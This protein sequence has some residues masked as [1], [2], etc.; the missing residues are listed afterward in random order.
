MVA[1]S[2][3]V[4]YNCKCACASPAERHRLDREIVCI[5]ARGDTS[6]LL[7]GFADLDH[8][9]GRVGNHES[10]KKPWLQTCATTKRVLFAN[11]PA[12]NMD[13]FFM[14]WIIWLWSMFPSAAQ[15]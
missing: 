2:Q 8:L 6:L 4:L 10:C 7:L 5:E 12:P 9:G 11:V 14:K 13:R 1:S 3:D 15:S